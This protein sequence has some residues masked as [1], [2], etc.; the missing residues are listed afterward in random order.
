LA[1][2]GSQANAQQSRFAGGMVVS[3]VAGEQFN[4]NLVILNPSPIRIQI[5][6]HFWL[7]VSITELEG[8]DR[9]KLL[10]LRL[11]AT[12]EAEQGNHSS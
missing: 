10:T 6:R 4:L 1:I 5:L 11:P 8:K 3:N 7:Y 2:E 12:G 9:R